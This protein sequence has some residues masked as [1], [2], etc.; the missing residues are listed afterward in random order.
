MTPAVAPA[1]LTY[2]HSFDMLTASFNDVGFWSLGMRATAP[3]R[4]IFLTDAD[5]VAFRG[6]NNR[7]QYRPL[8]GE[9]YVSTFFFL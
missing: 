2:A 9:G 8:A 3:A 4:R 6:P 5:V 7:M 1:Q